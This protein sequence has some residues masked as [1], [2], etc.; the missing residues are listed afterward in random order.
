M[1]LLGDHSVWFAISVAGTRSSVY[2]ELL[3]RDVARVAVKVE[4]VDHACHRVI[5]VDCST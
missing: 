1:N 2:E 4:L 5:Q 3:V